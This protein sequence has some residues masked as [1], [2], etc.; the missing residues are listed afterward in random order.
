[1][2]LRVNEGKKESDVRAETHLLARLKAIPTPQPIG[3]I[4]G[5]GDKWITL[6]PW[7]PGREAHAL[8]DAAICGEALRLIH[9]ARVDGGL[10]PNHYTLDELSRR[11]STFESDARFAEIV[12]ALARELASARTRHRGREELIHQDLFPDNLLVAD[13]HL[14]AILDFE[15]AT[16]G[17]LVY[18]V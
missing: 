14:A 5:F 11:L 6:F 13:D 8:A 10:P 17:P 4:V 12:P 3:D 18:D 9:V 7:V 1:F 16:R 15:Q 2:F